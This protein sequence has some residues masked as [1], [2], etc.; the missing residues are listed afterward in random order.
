MAIIIGNNTMPTDLAKRGEYEYP[1]YTVLHQTGAD[2][3]VRSRYMSAAFNYPQGL[4]KTH[5]QWW[6]DTVLQ[7]QQSRTFDSGQTIRLKN[8]D[9]VETVYTR[10]IVHRPPRARVKRNYRYEAVTIRITGITE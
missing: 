3:G 10:C 4:S 6:A 9:G 2:E 8:A 7:G 5:F 1:E